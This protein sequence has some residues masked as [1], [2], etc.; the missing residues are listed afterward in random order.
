MKNRL[1]K[2][3]LLFVVSF[4]SIFSLAAASQD[5][6]SEAQKKDAQI[7]GVIMVVDTSEIKASEV[8]VT[9]T[10]N[11]HIKKFAKDM[12]KGHG[13]N[14]EEAGKL[15]EKINIMPLA[16]PLANEIMEK[17][18]EGIVKLE[19]ADSSSFN[20]IYMDAMVK[21][22]EAAL[23]VI[24]TQLLPHTSNPELVKFLKKTRAAVAHH[25]QMAIDTQNK[26]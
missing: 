6:L 15:S 18:K 8:A 24:D 1:F 13:K 14:L 4:F 22:H 23:K 26:L 3:F 9:R 21:D 12:I 20:K 17:A 5:N 19:S 11:D 25:L 7:L 2:S 10:S 16:S